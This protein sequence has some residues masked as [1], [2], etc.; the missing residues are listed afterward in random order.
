MGTDDDGFQAS[1]KTEGSVGKDR[2]SFKSSL[3][4]SKRGSRKSTR[5]NLPSYT[6][7]GGCGDDDEAYVEITLDVGDDSV[8]VY[9]VKPAAGLGGG[10]ED[11]EDPEVA[12]LARALERRPTSFG[13][14]LIRNASSRIRQASQELRRLASVTKRPT[15]AKLDRTKS[16]AAHAL[17]GLKFITKS[18]G[19]SAW[20]AVEKRFDELAVDGE[21]QRSHFG[22]CIGNFVSSLHFSEIHHFHCSITNWGPNQCRH[23]RLQGVRRRTFRRAEKEEKHHRGQDQ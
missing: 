17:K 3:R 11:K 20:P 2:V 16:A 8:E 23:E 14:S 5:F 1:D 22:Q 18:E 19:A 21:L 10:V 4:L 9:S 6:G 12:L 15:P 13:S 7:A